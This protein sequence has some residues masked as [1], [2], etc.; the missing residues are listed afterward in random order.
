MYRQVRV[1]AEKTALFEE[2][3]EAENE[4]TVGVE[5][6]VEEKSLWCL[7]VGQRAYRSKGRQWLTK[8][9]R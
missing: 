8:K 9:R 3:E 2:Y 7:E 1:D 4:E 6:L 5:A